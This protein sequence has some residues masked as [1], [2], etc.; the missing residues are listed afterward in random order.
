MVYR[1][2]SGRKKTRQSS[3][4]SGTKSR[5]SKK[6][7]GKARRKNTKEDVRIAKDVFVLHKKT[8]FRDDYELA[9]TLGEGAY[10]VVGKCKNIKTGAIRAVKRLSKSN[11]TEK[12]L[13]D[14]ANEIQIVKKLDHPNIVKMYEEYEDSKYLYI[15]TE[16]IE[17]GELFDEL[18][19]RKKF[20]EKDCGMIIKQLLE[21]LTYCHAENIVHKDLK[22]ENILLEKKKDISTIKLID[23]GTAQRFDRKKKM[24]TVIGTPYYVA[25][26]VLKGSYD[27][28]CDI[29]GVGVIM[30]ILL[31]GT[32][33]FN[34]SDDKQI[35]TAVA[36]GKYEFKPAKWKGVS[37][38]AKNLISKMLVL[39]TE[40]RISAQEALDHGWFTMLAEDTISD[41]KLSGALKDLKKFKADCTMQQAALSYIVTHLATREE[42][43]DLDEAFKT[44]DVN[45]DGKLS[46]DELIQ[47]CKKVFPEMSEQEA[48]ELFKEADT[49]HSGSIDYSEWIQATIDKKNL[50]N[51]KNLRNAFN[52]FDE[53]G[54]GEIE[55]DEIKKLL[56]AGQD[57]DDGV[58]DDIIAEADEDNNGIIDFE[59][60]KHMMNKF[61]E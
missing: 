48:K 55:V 17:G 16:L 24:T 60:F 13:K 49:D 58:W 46:L 12:E 39:D 9:E 23:F 59:E 56:G 18:L 34:G 8:Q 53:N 19:R 20:T 15:V 25:P 5:E 28:K 37:E 50:L 43:K 3:N 32:P 2:E 7:K 42:T 21:A 51:E 61:I 1:S 44:L 29:W 54:D 52:A 40:K 27:E 6:S 57:F 41:K 47:G 35:T 10:G 26:E 11:I 36:K 45:H 30:F 4:R 14:I 38:E 33:P 31:S 22:P